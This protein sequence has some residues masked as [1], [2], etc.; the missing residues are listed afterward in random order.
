MAAT[1]NQ[2]PFSRDYI[3]ISGLR[4]VC[5]LYSARNLGTKLIE[6]EATISKL[7]T[8]FRQNGLYLFVI[9]DFLSINAIKGH[10]F[11]QF[12]TT[13]YHVSPPAISPYLR[14]IQACLTIF[15]CYCTQMADISPIFRVADQP[16]PGRWLLPGGLGIEGSGQ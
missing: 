9:S 5:K 10:N 8:S 15:H 14:H 6:R 7:G 11:P 4:R 16:G 12:V 2:G 3:P 13:L 1:S